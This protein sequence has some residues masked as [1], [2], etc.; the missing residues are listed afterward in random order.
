VPISNIRNSQNWT[1]IK[2]IGWWKNQEG[3]W[4]KIWFFVEP[5]I[6]EG[7]SND[8]SLID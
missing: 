8:K 3:W 2:S 4:F 1:E 7:V 6:V 5:M